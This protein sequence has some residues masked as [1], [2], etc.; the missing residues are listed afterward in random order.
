MGYNFDNEYT[1]F[2]SNND[3]EN[4]YDDDGKKIEYTE[5][6]LKVLEI[7]KKREELIK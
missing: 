4:E 1:T 7:E 5:E 3:S 2:S 6:E